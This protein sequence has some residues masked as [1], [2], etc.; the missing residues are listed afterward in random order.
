[1]LYPTIQPTVPVNVRD[2]SQI[3]SLRKI[4]DIEQYV[5]RQIKERD[6]LPLH[7]IISPIIRNAL[8]YPGR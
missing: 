1:M 6:S 5:S 4:E 3:F 8:A 2:K 7:Q